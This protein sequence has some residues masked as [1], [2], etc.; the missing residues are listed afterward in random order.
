[1]GEPLGS[2]FLL[3]LSILVVQLIFLLLFLFFSGSNTSVGMNKHNALAKELAVKNNSDMNM[4][5]I[6]SQEAESMVNSFVSPKA[7]M[8]SAI[9][10]IRNSTGMKS[11]SLNNNSSILADSATILLSHEE[12]M[13]NDFIHLYD[14]PLYKKTN[15]HIT[16]R[17]PCNTNSI[18]QL[19]I[20]ITNASK[21]QP[22]SLHL[23][24]DFS[25]PGYVCM[26]YADFTQRISDDHSKK[27]ND[28]SNI[29]NS[30]NPPSTTTKKVYLMNPMKSQIGLPNTSS[31]VIDVTGSG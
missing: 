23:V 4:G 20:V 31:V 5:K 9:D 29:K 30:N 11:A 21:L 19:N 17:L 25:K 16:A 26:Y 14:L 22:L 13:Q 10:Q 15:A 6:T 8:A 1:M 12:I 3:T 7:L 28:D 27:I 18:S 24:K 2:R